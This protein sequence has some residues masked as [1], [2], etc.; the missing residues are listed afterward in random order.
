MEAF[1]TI[2]V[3]VILLFVIITITAFVITDIFFYRRKTDF[4]SLLTLTS[5]NRFLRNDPIG[6]TMLR[7][8][9]LKLITWDEMYENIE[10]YETQGKRSFICGPGKF[11]GVKEITFKFENERGSLSLIAITLDVDESSKKEVYLRLK[12]KI[13]ERLGRPSICPED[14][15]LATWEDILLVNNEIGTNVCVVYGM[16]KQAM[17]GL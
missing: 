9:W 5:W 1:I 7:A 16:M 2:C 12:D 4:V 14:H 15:D 17:H 3:K 10:A 8:R 13:T 11:E 6:M